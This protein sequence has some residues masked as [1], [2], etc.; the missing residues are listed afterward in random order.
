MGVWSTQPQT[1]FCLHL[2]SLSRASHGF[3]DSRFST[4]VIK[5]PIDLIGMFGLRYTYSVELYWGP[6][7][8]S[9]LFQSRAHALL[10]CFAAVVELLAIIYLQENYN[11][12][13]LYHLTPKAFV[14]LDKLYLRH[15]DILLLNICNNCTTLV[16]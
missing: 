12:Y 1:V 14:C 16:N 8:L 3:H 15:L 5:P 9:L 11:Q 2:Q 4:I 6:K 7:L 10:A 13:F